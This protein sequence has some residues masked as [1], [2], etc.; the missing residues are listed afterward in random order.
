MTDEEMFL[1]Y[2]YH[3]RN[4]ADGRAI[5]E[6]SISDLLHREPLRL[7]AAQLM[8]ESHFQHRCLKPVP[9]QCYDSG[10]LENSPRTGHKPVKSLWLS[11]L[12]NDW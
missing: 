6:T 8:T 7:N 12:L 5:G 9:I 3:V 4:M 11:S 2:T 1:N 10:Q